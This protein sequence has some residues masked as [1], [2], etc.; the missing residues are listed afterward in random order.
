MNYYYNKSPHGI[1]DEDNNKINKELENEDFGVLTEIDVPLNTKEKLNADFYN[2][3]LG[4]CN[5]PY[6]HTALNDKTKIGI[7]LPCNVIVQV[8]KSGK[9]DEKELVAIKSITSIYDVKNEAPGEIAKSGKKLKRLFQNL[10]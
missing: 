10:N 1:F 7:I 6:A 3:L 5:A 2:D 9:A 4:T 8:K